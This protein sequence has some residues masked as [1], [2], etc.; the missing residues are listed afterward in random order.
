M[1]EVS[2]ETVATFL[3]RPRA[4]VTWSVLDGHGIPARIRG[5][6]VGGYVGL[7]LEEVRVEVPRDQAEAAR[8]LLD[9]I[10]HE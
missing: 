2:W 3:H 9:S 1:S 5:G 8:A 4:D 7:A 6:Y 10:D